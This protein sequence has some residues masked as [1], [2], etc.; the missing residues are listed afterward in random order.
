[1]LAKYGNIK[2]TKKT[3]ILPY[4]QAE[5]GGNGNKEAGKA[6]IPDIVSRLSLPSSSQNESCHLQQS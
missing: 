4:L 2:P 5:I 6:P 1:M 3:E